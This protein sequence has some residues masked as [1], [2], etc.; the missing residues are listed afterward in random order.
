MGT[1][2]QRLDALTQSV[3]LAQTGGVFLPRRIVIDG[4][5]ATVMPALMDRTGDHTGGRN[6]HM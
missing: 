6:V 2:L 4:E 1:L 5:K 3:K